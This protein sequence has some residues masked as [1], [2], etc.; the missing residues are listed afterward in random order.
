VTLRLDVHSSETRASTEQL[1]AGTTNESTL[2]IYHFTNN[3]AVLLVE[4]QLVDNL[5]E[6]SASVYLFDQAVSTQAIDN[7]I[8]NRHSDEQIAGAPEPTEITP[9]SGHSIVFNTLVSRESTDEGTLR[10]NYHLEFEVD[11]LSAP[12]FILADFQDGVVVPTTTEISL[13]EKTLDI[14]S[15]STSITTISRYFTPFD[16]GDTLRMYFFEDQN[17]VLKLVFPNDDNDFEITGSINLFADDETSEAI[18]AWM[19]NQYSDALLADAPE[20]FTTEIEDSAYSIQS[21]MLIN[22]EPGNDGFQYDNY[23]VSF[24]IDSISQPRLFHLANFVDTVTVHVRGEELSH[25][26]RVLDVGSDQTEVTDI[27]SYESESSYGDTLLLYH[28]TDQNAVLKLS[29][30]NAD[31]EFEFTASL[32]LFAD[33]E[34]AATVRDWINNQHSD[35]VVPDAPEPTT[36]ITLNDS[37]R[38]VESSVLIDS[39]SGGD[40]VNYDNYQV[41]FFV[42][43]V[44]EAGVVHLSSFSDMVVVHVPA[45]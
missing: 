2:Q 10:E 36:E 39:E 3:K 1:A 29:F 32:H 42:D 33:S 25:T 45:E 31:T 24:F 8:S 37:Q 6:V 20:P 12:R 17:S 41:S 43:V 38:A 26:E 19:E 11:A 27:S 30:P 14:A 16:Y 7:W 18:A 4:F 21:T 22:A 9:V 34:T 35:A 13:T 5:F 40:G 15:P 44:S 23:S 28:F